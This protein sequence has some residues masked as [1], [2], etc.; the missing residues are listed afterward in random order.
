MTKGPNMF[1]SQILNSEMNCKVPKDNY[2]AFA[3]G[4]DK[5]CR[6]FGKKKNTGVNWLSVS[7]TI[8]LFVACLFVCLCSKLAKQI[9]TIS[10]I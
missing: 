7:K 3:H 10:R 5:I 4:I 1:A 8:E 9:P 6:Y 2:A